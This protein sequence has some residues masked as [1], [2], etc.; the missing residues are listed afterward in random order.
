MEKEQSQAITTIPVDRLQPLDDSDTLKQ[1]DHLK[2]E[3]GKSLSLEEVME[4]IWRISRSL[5]PHDRIGISFI[6]SDRERVTSVYFK[7]DYPSEEVHLGKGYSAGLAHSSLRGILE[8]RSAR[9]INSLNG[10]LKQNPD[11]TSTRLLLKEKVASNLTLPLMVD[12]REVGF[13]FFS[14]REEG[15]FNH[16][17]ANILLTVLEIM[18]QNIEKIWLIKKREESRQDY[19]NM[20]GFVSHEMKSPLAAMMSVGSTYLKGYTGK[21]DPDAGAI[22]K[23]MMKISGYLINMVKNYLDMSRLESGEMQFQPRKGIKFIEDVLDFALETVAPRA[24]ERENRLVKSLPRSDVELEGDTDLLRIVAVNLLDNAIKYGNEK[25]DVSI[26]VKKQ[27]NQLVFSVENQGVGFTKDQSRK[28]FKRFSR[29][30]Q[31]GLED[32]RGSGLGLYLTWWIVQKHRGHI[33]AQSEPGKWARFTV[34]LKI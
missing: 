4:L 32:R 10:Y 31:E 19:L 25:S 20:L 22:V 26:S 1:L 16:E 5:L 23:K 2:R 18:A 17:H 11:S 29:L 15:V 34:F 14:S 12:N 7:T 28:L 8:K 21:V 13:L 30:K 3:M 9:I 27:K 24:E 33:T 6:D